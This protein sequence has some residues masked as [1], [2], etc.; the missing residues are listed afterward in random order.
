MEDTTCVLGEDRASSPVVERSL[1]TAPNRTDAGRQVRSGRQ[2]TREPAGCSTLAAR[3][4]NTPVRRPKIARLW[5]QSGLRGLRP[6]EIA[7]SWCRNGSVARDPQHR[8][9]RR[10][11]SHA[12]FVAHPGGDA[13]IPESGGCR[14]RC[15]GIRDAGRE[16]IKGPV[17]PSMQITNR[18]RPPAGGGPARVSVAVRNERSVAELDLVREH[19]RGGDHDRPRERDGPCHCRRQNERSCEHE[20]GTDT[21]SCIEFQHRTSRHRA[22]SLGRPHEPIQTSPERWRRGGGSPPPSLGVAGTTFEPKP[23][24]GRRDRQQHERQI[25]EDTTPSTNAA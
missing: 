18:S 4:G 21:V 12:A 19:A 13:V 3:P 10:P 2:C 5:E 1:G 23:V 6:H 14:R 7:R 16:T 22:P 9:T 25:E 11:R 20:R 24:G 17:E 15:R 8:R